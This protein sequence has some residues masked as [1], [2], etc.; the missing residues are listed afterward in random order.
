MSSEGHSISTE[1]EWIYLSSLGEMKSCIFPI[2]L[3]QDTLQVVV[4]F[5]Q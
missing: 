2:R 4:W 3:W 5:I 1:A